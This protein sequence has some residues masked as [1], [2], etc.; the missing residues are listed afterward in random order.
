MTDCCVASECKPQSKKV[1]GNKSFGGGA[2]RDRVCRVACA[3]RAASALPLGPRLRP[4]PHAHAWPS[5][6]LRLKDDLETT[7]IEHKSFLSYQ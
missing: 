6:R 5:G 4:Q 3:P 7:G 1:G 2:C